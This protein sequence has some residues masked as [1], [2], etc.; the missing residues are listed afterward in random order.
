MSL[1]TIILE[2]ILQMTLHGIMGLKG[3]TVD[4]LEIL[5]M[6]RIKD[7]FISLGIELNQTKDVTA[8]I[9]LFPIV[10]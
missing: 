7:I 5:G 10:G 6:G 9:K 2:M 1:A 8:L 4:E 3:F